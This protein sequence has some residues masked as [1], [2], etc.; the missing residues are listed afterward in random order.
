MLGNQI[1]PVK[2]RQLKDS[3]KM[4]AQATQGITGLISLKSS[5]FQN[6]LAPRCRLM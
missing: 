2:A 6:A 4:S 1:P 3:N 5:D